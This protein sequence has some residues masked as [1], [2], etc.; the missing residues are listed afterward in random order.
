MA[1][2]FIMEFA[3]GTAAQYD[4]VIA[5]MNLGGRPAPGGIFHVAGPMDGGWR[6]VDVWE[7]PEVFERFRVE[8]IEPI[9]RKHGVGAPRVTAFP[10]HNILR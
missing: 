3:G 4:A 9:T 2:A 7:S 8:Q 6:V 5:D 1:M 10:V